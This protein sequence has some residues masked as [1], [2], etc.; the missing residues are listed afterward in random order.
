MLSKAK[1]KNYFTNDNGKLIPYKTKKGTYRVPGGKSLKKVIKT[2]DK[3][4]LDFL[5]KC[6]TWDPDDRMNPTE[7][8]NH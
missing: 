5:K 6:L 8:L 2:E 7:A 1:R 3:V 4:F